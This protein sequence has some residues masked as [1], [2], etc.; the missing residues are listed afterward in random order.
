MAETNRPYK[1]VIVRGGR[2]LQVDSAD[3][4][5]EANA[6]ARQLMA[7]NRI[8]RDIDSLDEGNEAPAP[9][10]I[11]VRPPSHGQRITGVVRE[12]LEFLGYPWSG[13]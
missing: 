5:A 12:A 7:R 1:V 3:T 4:A 10:H 13:R 9:L 11:A 8:I 2:D 6:K